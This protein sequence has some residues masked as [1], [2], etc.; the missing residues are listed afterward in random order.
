[1]KPGVKQRTRLDTSLT[2]KKSTPLANIE[3]FGGLIERIRFF[4]FFSGKEL[5]VFSFPVGLE[6][7]LG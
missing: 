7:E 1:M 2:P 6:L 4:F 5:V 3:T